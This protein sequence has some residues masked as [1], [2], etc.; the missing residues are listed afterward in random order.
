MRLKNL[1]HGVK[2]KVSGKGLLDLDIKDISVHS[3]KAG[4]GV[5]FI[6]VK[7]EV[8]DS[9]QA[10]PEM[11]ERGC[12]VCVVEKGYQP[13]PEFAD[14][15]VWVEDGRW[16]LSLIAANFFSH[17]SKDVKI[18]A[19][20]GTNGKTTT[21]FLLQHIVNQFSSCGL[22]GTI[23]NSIGIQELPALNTTPGPYD[24]QWMLSLMRQVRLR[25]CAMEISS[26][27]L[28]QKRA[29]H[30]FAHRAVF[31]N[32][33][34]DH[35]D[36]HHDMDAYFAAK[37]KLF[38]GNPAPGLSYVNV[39]DVYG[40]ELVSKMSAPVKTFAIKHPADFMASE[41]KA[42][43]D[44]TSFVIHWEK[45]ATPVRINMPCL[46][47]IYNVLGAFACAVDEGWDARAVAQAIA[48]FRG[49]PGRMERAVYEKDYFV[50]VD[51]AHTPKAVESVLRSVR[52]LT[53]GRLITVIGC[54]GNRDPLKRAPMGEI[55]ARYSD[56]VIFTS[57]N[58]RKE[59]PEEILRQ[60][61]AG[62]PAEWKHKTSTLI[63]RREAI[64]RALGLAKKGDAV[65]ILGK[66]HENYQVVGETKYPFDD[67]AVVLEIA[68][69]KAH[70]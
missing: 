25:Y 46:H 62:V 50:F 49:V 33:T 30:L 45:G 34:H 5:L 42:G 48:S 37:S 59:D 65:L 58:P 9:H 27:A 66:G 70:V 6:A 40:R 35:L 2:Y 18:F 17:P 31:T 36:Y 60:I 44:G 12:A 55:A 32:L 23:K 29:A 61:N 63:D 14:K 3:S 38:L 39:D 1:L 22:T 68:G 47:N 52:P 51:Y 56:Q 7:G 20:T 41:I 28:E 26:H 57:D 69:E 64:A 67:R 54:G 21:T 4:E 10:V 19:V 13:R 11:F 24:L 53:G 8:F 15:C 16:S 43:L